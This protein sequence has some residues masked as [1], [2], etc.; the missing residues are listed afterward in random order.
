[1]MSSVKLL[2]NLLDYCAVK[3]KVIAKNISNVG[4]QGYKREDVEF[5][6]LLDENSN[7]ILR[8]SSNKHLSA[9]NNPVQSDSGFNVVL[10]DSK[11][12]TTGINNVDIEQEMS[13]L[14]ENTLRFRFASRK[15]GDYYK[16]IQNVIK[17]GGRF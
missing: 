9:V 1:M 16:S 10:D 4:T 17:G 8:I 12:M 2:Q 7:S 14:A 15:V 5:K 13:E 11:E 3:N 6:N